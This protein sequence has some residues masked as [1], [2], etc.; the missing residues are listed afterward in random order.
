MTYPVD[1]VIPVWNRPVETRASLA[2][3]VD[4]SPDARIIMVNYGSERETERILEE[5]ADALDDRAIL[6]STER[7]VGRVA[8]L[9]HGIGLATARVV[10]IVHDGLAVDSIW[11]DPLLALM[12][13][14]PDIGLALPVLNKQIS[15]TVTIPYQEVEHGSLGLMAI[16]RELFSLVGGF[17]EHMDGGIWC[18]RDYSRRA[19]RA[20]YR[21]IAVASCRTKI[22][23]PQLLGSVTR[24]E[25]RVRQGEQLY[26]QRWGIQRHFCFALVGPDTGIQSHSVLQSLLTA[27]RQG[28]RITLLADKLNYRQLTGD[29]FGAL[30]AGISIESLPVLF[31]L[32]GLRKRLTLLGKDS[33]EMLFVNAAHG[34]DIDLPEIC[35][36]DFERMIED[37]SRKFFG[38]KES[39]DATQY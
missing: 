15:A 7:N 18:L 14:R 29:G 27:A 25:D 35:L 38:T 30:H 17:D 36:A 5:F 10:L 3:L 2:A 6:V 4:Q 34:L 23:E 21:T 11:L 37:R 16:R 39:S 19:E 22:E 31:T 28:D 20:G 1:I 9:N 12:S 33:P 24:R 13:E 26:Q 8:A 32:R